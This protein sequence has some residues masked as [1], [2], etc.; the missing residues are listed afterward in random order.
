MKI[1]EKTIHLNECILLGGSSHIWTDVPLPEK[2][3]DGAVMTILK[4]GFGDLKLGEKV[5]SVLEGGFQIKAGKKLEYKCCGM[6]CMT[7]HLLE[8]TFLDHPLVIDDVSV[9][10]SF[11]Q[12]MF[13]PFKDGVWRLDLIHKAGKQTTNQLAYCDESVVEKWVRL[14]FSVDNLKSLLGRME[15]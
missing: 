11:Y 12:V 6:D 9:L 3:P 4:T 14:H 8:Y 15:G 7:L 2:I 10:L 5:M 13:S 1:Q